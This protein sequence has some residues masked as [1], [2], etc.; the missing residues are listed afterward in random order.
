MTTITGQ[1]A[2]SAQDPGIPGLIPGSVKAWALAEHTHGTTHSNASTSRN[3]CVLASTKAITTSSIP[4][5]QAGRASDRR[6]IGTSTPSS[7]AWVGA[8]LLPPPT[9]HYPTTLTLQ[10]EDQATIPATGAY[11]H[12]HALTVTPCTFRFLSLPRLHHMVRCR[13][14]QN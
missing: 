12:R 9:T 5:C 4:L 3:L 2:K 7:H 13:S 8:E 10:A 14:R 1:F 6:A 11:R